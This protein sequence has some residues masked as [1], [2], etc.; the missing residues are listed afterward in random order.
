[1]N[2]S[3]AV[4]LTLEHGKKRVR[5]AWFQLIISLVSTLFSIIVSTVLYLWISGGKWSGP[6]WL[7]ILWVIFT[8]LM[9]LPRI[10]R[11]VI[12]KRTLAGISPQLCFTV[13][14]EGIAFYWPETLRVAWA[15]IDDVRVIRKLFSPAKLAVIAAGKPVAT[16]PL[17]LLDA[18]PAV[19]DAMIRGISLG[20]WRLNARKLEMSV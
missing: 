19:L 3:F 4:G 13:E 5:A 10:A 14:P 6:V 8:V 9:L 2:Q 15:D 17:H 18:P 12:E 20:D 7:I 16:V 11:L 1:M